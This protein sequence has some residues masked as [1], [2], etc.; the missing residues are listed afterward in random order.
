MVGDEFDEL[1]DVVL[2]ICCV[3][4]VCFV[5]VGVVVDVVGVE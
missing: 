4:F 1:V 5:E 2:W 3:D